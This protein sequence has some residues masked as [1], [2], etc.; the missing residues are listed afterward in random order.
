MGTTLSALSPKPES[1]SSPVEVEK[2]NYDDDNNWGW[3]PG[4]CEDRDKPG[5]QRY[6]PT[7][8]FPTH[9]R[10]MTNGKVDPIMYDHGGDIQDTNVDVFFVHVSLTHSARRLGVSNIFLTHCLCAASFMFCDILPKTI[11]RHHH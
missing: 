10:N 11:S 7:S 9:A 3:L 6:D 8:V 4:R 5:L 2:V 1:P